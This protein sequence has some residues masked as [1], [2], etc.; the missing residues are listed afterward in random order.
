MSPLMF[1]TRTWHRCLG[2]QGH[3]EKTIGPAWASKAKLPA[4]AA[5]LAQMSWIDNLTSG[6]IWP[7][8][9]CPNGNGGLELRLLKN[10]QHLILGAGLADYGL[11]RNTVSA[12][13][14]SP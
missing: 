7:G 9:N 6:P 11:T 3:S 1:L 12:T 2:S 4:K 13:I 10:W 8:S 14:L 5:S